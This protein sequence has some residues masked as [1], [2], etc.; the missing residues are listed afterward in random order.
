LLLAIPPRQKFFSNTLQNSWA[1]WVN[2]FLDRGCFYSGS[3][4][5]CFAAAST[6]YTPNDDDDMDGGEIAATVVLSVFGALLLLLLVVFLIFRPGRSQTFQ[7]SGPTRQ[8]DTV[9][10]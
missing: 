3:K 6:P 10:A 7:G 5:Q 1:V 4:V 9:D 8:Q 2:V